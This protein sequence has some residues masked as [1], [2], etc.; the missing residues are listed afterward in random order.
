MRNARVLDVRS[1]DEKQRR[2]LVWNPR[3]RSMSA[4]CNNSMLFSRELDSF[5]QTV[6][7]KIFSNQPLP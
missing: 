4:H 3:V 5:G 7:S 1:R 6:E 2:N